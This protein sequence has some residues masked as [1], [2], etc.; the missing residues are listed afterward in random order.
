MRNPPFLESVNILNDPVPAEKKV[1]KFQSVDDVDIILTSFK[2]HFTSL[3]D[4]AMRI[5]EDEYKKE[6]L[7]ELVKNFTLD[8]KSLKIGQSMLKELAAKGKKV[9]ANCMERVKFTSEHIKKIEE[10][11]IMV[12]SIRKLVE[13]SMQD[14]N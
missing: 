14:M 2:A 3:V 6:R 11:E 7:I 5:A 13:T 8:L 9:I 4:S 10:A 1:E 12:D